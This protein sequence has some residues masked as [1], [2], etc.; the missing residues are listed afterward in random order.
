MTT[1]LDSILSGAEA[2]ASAD[3]TAPV[4]VVAPGNPRA[5]LAGAA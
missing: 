5:S 3:A 4:P 1:S 2:N